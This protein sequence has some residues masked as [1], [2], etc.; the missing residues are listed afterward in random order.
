[1]QNVLIVAIAGGVWG[2]MAAGAAVKRQPTTQPQPQAVQGLLGGRFKWKLGPPLVGP[3][4]RAEDPCH[5]IKDPSIVRY[6]GR[7]HL[8]CS[9]RSQ[10]RSHQIEYLSFADWKDAHAATRHV[11]KLSDGYFCAPQVFYFSPH[12]TWYLIC[13]VIEKSRKPAL[14]PACSTTENIADPSSWSAPKLLFSRQP[15]GIGRWID[16]WVICDRTRAH[17]YFTSLDGRMWR[18][19]TKLADFPHG[20]GQPSVVLRGDVFEASHTYRLRGLDKHLTLIEA[21]AGGRRYYKAYVAD[22]LDGKWAPLAASKRK[23]FASPV[24]VQD[25]AAHWTDSFSHGEL[26]RWG[27]DETLQ[28]DP[29]NIRFLFQGVSDRDRQGRQ[30]GQIPWRLGILEPAP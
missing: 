28:V 11:L 9:I 23:P 17:L 18:T 25:V 5:A 4:D 7:W 21:Q 2:C 1:M 8:F 29:A 12:K 27:Y 26:I 13:Q 14:Q 3:A 6:R 15:K 19:E 30:Y 16:F 10:K 20:W 24:N 22:R